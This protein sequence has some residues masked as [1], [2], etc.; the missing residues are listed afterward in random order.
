MHRSIPNC[1]VLF[2]PI[3]LESFPGK[4][5]FLGLH[6]AFFAYHP[7]SDNTFLSLKPSTITKTAGLIHCG[8]GTKLVINPSKISSRLSTVEF[9]RLCDDLGSGLTAR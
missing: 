5:S 9:T 8:S 1:T 4:S 6:E 2:P 3:L 7:G